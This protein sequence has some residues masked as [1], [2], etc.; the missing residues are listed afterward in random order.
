[1]VVA[2][3]SHLA[4]LDMLAATEQPVGL[5]RMGLQYR[6]VLAGLV[7]VRILVEQ[8]LPVRPTNRMAGLGAAAAAESAAAREGRAVTAVYMAVAVV[9]VE[10]VGRLALVE[11]GRQGS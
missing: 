5:L 3:A 8:G 10:V 6:E 2:A 7:A 9:V 1:V 11:A 4:A